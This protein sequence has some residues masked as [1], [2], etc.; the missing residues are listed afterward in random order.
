MDEIEIVEKEIGAVIEIEER[1]SVWKMQSVMSKDFKSIMEYLKSK[2]VDGKEAPYARYLDIDWDLEMKRGAL[3]DFIRVLTKQ[4][5]F[6]VG[7]PT[8]TMT[9]GAD[10]LICRRIQNKKFVKAFH[11]GPYRKIGVTYKKMYA[12]A[13]DRDLSF[14]SESI[15]FYLNDPRET[16]KESL[17]TM[18]LIPVANT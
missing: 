14:E 16:K 7:I 18:V 3:A 1:V 12:W 10:N 9:E 15:E 6:Q 4:W 13:R 17:K 11:Y 5:H 8:A 2:G